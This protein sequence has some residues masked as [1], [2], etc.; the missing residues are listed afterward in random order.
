MSHCDARVEVTDDVAHSRR[1]KIIG[2]RHA[3]AG[4][5]GIVTDGDGKLLAEDAATGVEVGHGLLGAL[6]E[7]QAEGRV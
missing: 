6:L 3:L 2:D 5:G 1:S 4:I 7:L